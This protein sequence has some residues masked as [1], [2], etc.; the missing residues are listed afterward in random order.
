M[1]ARKNPTAVVGN[2]KDLSVPL[3]MIGLLP[4]KE[5]VSNIYLFSLWLFTTG[6]FLL[7]Y[8]AHRRKRITAVQPATPPLASSA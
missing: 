2:P 4:I 5:D 8:V 3:K 1:Q 7:E 6:F